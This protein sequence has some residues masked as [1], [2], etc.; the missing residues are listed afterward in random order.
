MLACPGRAAKALQILLLH[1]LLPLVLVPAGSVGLPGPAAGDWAGEP[2]LAQAHCCPVPGSGCCCC[3]CL[4]AGPPGNCIF[5]PWLLSL[6]LALLLLALVSVVSAAVAACCLLRLGLFQLGLW[7][8][9]LWA[10]V[11]RATVYSWLWFCYLLLSQLVCCLQVWL[12]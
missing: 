8:C 4:G 12:A 2:G 3:G 10:D 9:L 6:A 11:P 7:L 1:V 5:K